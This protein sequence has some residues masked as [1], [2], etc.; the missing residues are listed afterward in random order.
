MEV[1][2]E[3]RSAGDPVW[4]ILEYDWNAIGP[5][6]DG[7]EPDKAFK[8]NLDVKFLFTPCCGRYRGHTNGTRGAHLRF[9][10]GSG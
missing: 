5:L 8:Q 4:D 3:E 6:L 1:D 7:Y 9:W 2:F 10:I